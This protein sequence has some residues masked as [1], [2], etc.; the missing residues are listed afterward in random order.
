MKINIKSTNMVLTEAIDDYTKKRINSLEKIISRYG[1][2]AF[3][4]IEV[5][6]TTNHHKAGDIFRAEINLSINGKDFRTE[7]TGE[8][9]YTTIDEAKDDLARKITYFKDKKQTL[10]KRGAISVKK[11]MKGLSKRNPFTSKYDNK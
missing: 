9:L 10:F 1:G 6:K 4:S 3:F 2:E 5:A 7:S 8:D 11:M